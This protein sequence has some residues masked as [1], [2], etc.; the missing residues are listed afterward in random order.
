MWPGKVSLY[1]VIFMLGGLTF[2][3]ASGVLHLEH[4]IASLWTAKSGVELDSPSDWVSENQIKV[5]N[6]GVE[7]M[8]N[9]AEWS[10]FTDTNS[11]DPVLDAGANA[12]EIPVKSESSIHPGDIISYK[13]DYGIIIHRVIEVGYDDQGWYA[14]TKGDNNAYPDPQKVRFN[15]VLRVVVAI[16]Y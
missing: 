3:L 7:I 13:S 1:L 9:N 2:N 6:N 11:M 15:Q 10:S 16:I 8:I 12:I 14:I 4:P 5:T